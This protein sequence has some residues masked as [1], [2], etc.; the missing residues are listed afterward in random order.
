M[1]MQIKATYSI[2]SGGAQTAT[3]A[4]GRVPTYAS[5][6]PSM[7]TSCHASQRF[8]TAP[9]QALACRRTL[10]T[11]TMTISP[12]KSVQGLHRCQQTVL[13]LSHIALSRSLL[14]QSTSC[15]Q[16][17]HGRTSVVDRY[18]CQVCGVSHWPSNPAPQLFVHRQLV[19]HCL[20]VLLQPGG[21]DALLAL[22]DEQRGPAFTPLPD[23]H[24]CLSLGLR[25]C[26]ILKHVCRLRSLGATSRLIQSSSRWMEAALWA[27]LL[28]HDASVWGW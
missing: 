18:R 25:A 22:C 11:T 4:A 23:V 2:C 10:V 21:S 15:W 3:H 28:W 8:K 5:N 1:Y 26:S 24:A 17:Q 16:V 20:C 6:S 9:A 27:E 12:S 19:L 14:V 7:P 13:F